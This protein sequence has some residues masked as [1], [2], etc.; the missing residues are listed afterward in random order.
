MNLASVK[1]RASQLP[2]LKRFSNKPWFYPA[3]LLL[4]GLVAHGYALG[5]LGYFW[6]D[7]EVVFLLNTRNLP[8]L[9]GYFA[10]DRPFAWPYQAMYAVFALNPIAWHLMTLLLR[11]AGVLLLYLSLRL[12]WPR[13]DSHLRWLGLLL[14]V[15]PGF[16]Q[17]SIS[18]AYNR[19]FTA[20]FLFALS[21][22]LMAVAVR[23]PKRAWF[24]FPLSWLIAF[25]Q[26]FTIEY[27]VGLEL[28]RPVF[29]WLLL[30]QDG[31]A[32]KSRALGKALLLF[33]PFFFLL[34]FYGW[35]RLI[36]FPSTLH[37]LNYAGDYKMLDE[38]HIS[39]A[40]GVLAVVTRAFYDL[41]YSTVQVWLAGLTKPDALTFQGKVA[42]FA[43]GAGTL[44]AAL[45]ALF[46]D[47]GVESNDQQRGSRLS[48]FLF[49]LFAFLVSGLP[50][51]IT[52]RQLSGTGR[53]DD[54]FSLAPM[55]GAGLMV[56][57][58]IAWLVRARQQKILL[59]LLLVCSIMVQILTV[60]KYRLE[61][62]IESDYYWQLAWRVPAL[63]PHTAIFSLEQPSVS[64]PGYDA[65]F[66]MN[67]L[68]HGNIVDGATPYWFFTNNRF[69]NF[70]FKPGKAIS[71][72][73]RN[74]KFSGNT[75][76][77]I[78]IVHQGQDR[79]LQ[80]LDSVY[81]GQPFYALDQEQLV[82]VSNVSRILPSGSSAPDPDIFG[83]EPPHTWCYYFQKADLARQLQ[84]WQSVLSL[85]KQAKALGLAPK[86]GA[87]YLPFIEAN[88]RTGDWQKA[89]ELSLSAQAVISEM[90]PLLCSTWI[91]LAALPSAD[92]SVVDRAKQAFS[93]STP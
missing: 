39:L 35:W 13:Y 72:T 22:Y 45:F 51:W 46:Q 75:S 3:A 14:L 1:A 50:F 21:L 10:Y 23:K 56:I 81:A 48:M 15:Y 93:C 12:L 16:L 26:I 37:K 36:V 77:A 61:W 43:L 88:A 65:S 33:L 28:I 85:E 32:Q 29:L 40:A 60:N 78:S 47:G 53:W 92:L 18:A 30:M 79:C 31:K 41:I 19:H 57:A 17:Q 64:I 44:L 89:Y 70:N 9:Y 86:F 7:W 71:Y 63:M 90:D 87:E 62:N 27:F 68:F 24:L 76:D 5:S 8:L 52:N 67:V 82:G 59:A 49:G 74:L 73:D 34:G 6:D 91:R 83:P 58:L 11:W 38:F 20:F 4:V 2:D 66:A 69:L 25:V 84:D 54:R 42:W 80:V 55:L